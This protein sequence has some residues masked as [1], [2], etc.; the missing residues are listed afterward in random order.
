MIIIGILLITLAI[1]YLY[2]EIYSM[3]TCGCLLLI[4][5]IIK[6]IINKDD[7]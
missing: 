7:D 2:G 1:N 6:S 4:Y 3:L 5:G